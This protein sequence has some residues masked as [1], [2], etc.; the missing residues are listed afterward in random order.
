MGVWEG[1]NQGLTDVLD[2]KERKKEAEAERE[3]RRQEAQDARDFQL[4]LQDRQ[5]LREMRTAT[6][7]VLAKRSQ[8][9]QAL[10]DKVSL[11]VSIGLSEAAATSLLRSGQLDLFISQ[12]QKNEKVDSSYVSNLSAVVEQSMP[13]A[14][15]ED[16]SAVL[17]SGVS[18]TRDVTD[19]AE[20]DAALTEAII[21]SSSTEELQKLY[22]QLQSEPVTPAPLPRFDVNFTAMAGPSY[23]DTNNISKEINSTLGTYF[24]DSFVQNQDGTLGVRQDAAPEVT[25]LFNEATRAAR[26]LAFG[27]QRQGTPTDAARFVS[28]QLEAAIRGTGGKATASDLL[29]NLGTILND[30][31]EFVSKF[32]VPAAEAPPIETPESATNALGDTNEF[33]FNLDDEFKQRK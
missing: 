24:K 1:I 8:A 19:P 4:M 3:L 5:D 16:A 31:N 6:L 12:Y 25:G 28:T 7:D 13:D 2:R 18:T 29:E 20:A 21:S 27:P 9:K 17:M 33:N 32:Q 11:G 10:K 15:P 22:L 23:E 30:P 14:S 26:D